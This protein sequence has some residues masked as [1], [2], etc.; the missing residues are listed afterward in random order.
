MDKVVIPCMLLL[1]MAMGLVLLVYIRKTQRQVH[2]LEFA[3][4]QAKKAMVEAREGR[5]GER[6]QG[7][8]RI[9]IQ[10]EP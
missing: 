6:K 8:K 7:E 5:G 10:C 2:E 3:R 1:V 9:F 4:N